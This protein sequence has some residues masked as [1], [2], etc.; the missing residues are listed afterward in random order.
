MT[1]QR[2]HQN[3][4]KG[5][6]GEI[7]ICVDTVDGLGTYIEAEKM[8]AGDADYQTIAAELWELLGKLDITKADQ[9]ELGYDVL[10]KRNS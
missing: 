7:E 2:P 5:R 3:P 4:P 9:E 10:L 1:L 6:V 8:C